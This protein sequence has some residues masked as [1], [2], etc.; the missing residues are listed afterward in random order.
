LKLRRKGGTSSRR[1]AH[2][3]QRAAVTDHFY[4]ALVLPLVEFVG[5]MGWSLC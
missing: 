4:S 3:R 2:R 1:K 5:R